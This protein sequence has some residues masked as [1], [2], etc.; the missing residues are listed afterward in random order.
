[1]SSNQQRPQVPQDINAFNEKLIAEFRAN[2]GRLSGPMEGRQLLLLTTKGAR[3]GMERTVV[4]GYR[5]HGDSYAIIASANGA[6]KAPAWY[7]NLMAD[8]VAAAEVGPEKF[9][10]RARVAEAGERAELA[11]R[12]E[13]LESQQAK[14]NREIPIVVLERI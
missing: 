2:A 11:K 4:V 8:P 7:H 5:P 6:P 12:I 3:S 14:T 1:M 13:Y 9:Q 10:V